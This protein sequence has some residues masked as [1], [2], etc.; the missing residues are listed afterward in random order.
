MA[1]R[2]HGVANGRRMLNGWRASPGLLSAIAGQQDDALQDSV[3][4]TRGREKSSFL[5]GQSDWTAERTSAHPHPAGIRAERPVLP[6]RW[7]RAG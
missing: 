3:W 4:G 7:R 2:C 1:R 6:C 5:Q